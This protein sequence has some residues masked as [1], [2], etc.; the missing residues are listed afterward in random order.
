MRVEIGDLQL[1]IRDMKENQDKI[2]AKVEMLEKRIP[3]FT[4]DQNDTNASVK[5]RI[6]NLENRVNSL[7]ERL[8]KKK[9]WQILKPFKKVK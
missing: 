1:K 7:F 9:F 4:K 6:F 8:T 5:K 3:S 2:E